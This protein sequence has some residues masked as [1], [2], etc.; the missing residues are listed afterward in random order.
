MKKKK[1]I[2]EFLIDFIDNE[3]CT[4][5]DF[6]MLFDIIKKQKILTK[7]EELKHFIH[8]LMSISNNR[9]HNSAFFTKITKILQLALTKFE[10]NTKKPLSNLEKFTLFYCNKVILFILIKNKVIEVDVFIANEI[11]NYQ[12]KQFQ[13]FVTFSFHKFSNSSTKKKK[14]KF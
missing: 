1:E 11:L 13:D 14:K 3:E 10:N 7:K 2:Q 8:L 9:H 4:N 12:K 5:Y 6:Y